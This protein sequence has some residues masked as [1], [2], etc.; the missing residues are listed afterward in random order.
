[1]RSDRGFRRLAIVTVAAVYLLILVGGLVRASGAGMGCPDWPTCFGR[2]VPPTSE[3]QLPADYQEIYAEHGYGETRFNV[4][5][6]WTEYL[7]R[8]LG[9]L[10]GLLIFAT[11][12][13]SWWSYWKLDRVVVWWSTA[14]FV[15]VAF[16]GW[17]GA[18]VVK[19][20]LTPWVVT[21]HLIAALLV[22][23]TLLL[24]MG[25]SRREEL[26]AASLKRERG[27]LF[28][29]TIVVGLSLIQVVLGTQVR[30]EIDVLMVSAESARGTWAAELGFV[31]LFHRSFSLVVLVANGLLARRFLRDAP[32]PSPLR[33]W[34]VLLVV[35]TTLEVVSGAVLYY[36]GFPA[37]LQ[38]VH[39][40]L[41]SVIVGIQFFLWMAYHH[42]TEDGRGLSRFGS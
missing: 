6:T 25:R 10:I 18:V 37:L 42:A 28:L 36:A 8:L 2:W 38:P 9:V 40:F 15:L 39:L 19:S 32:P 3:S 24:A 13:A 17:L 29:L 5:K 14:A 21:L 4:T 7:N 35:T 22:V 1:M 20:N 16:E 41:A 27:T 23:A 34:A 31:V 33:K 30:E 26:A 11:L 12:V